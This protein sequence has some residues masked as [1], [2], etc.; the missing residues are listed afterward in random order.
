[1]RK[2]I[3]I[4]PYFQLRFIFI[5]S[6]TAFAGIFILYLANYF[7]FD[8]LI[9]E[10]ISMDLP[11]EHSYFYF[12]QEQKELLS[13]IFILTSLGVFLI[14]FFLGL[15]YSHR[16]AGPLHYM[17]K[18]M[19]EIAQGNEIKELSFRKKDYFKELAPSFN[20]VIEYLGNKKK[21]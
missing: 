2:K 16:I 4:N 9:Q 11:T 20:A 12:I 8:H 19:Q 3:L 5:I 14:I 21:N 10:G 13:K 17:N 15:Y 7:F 1:M 18:Q 6:F